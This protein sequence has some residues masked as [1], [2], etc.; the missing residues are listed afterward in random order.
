MGDPTSFAFSE[1]YLQN[2]EN[3]KI[4]NILLTHHI[5][6]YFRYFD[7]IVIAYNQVQANI[8]TY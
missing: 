4:L 1:I 5:V 3:T 7:D 6:G 2:K 8:K